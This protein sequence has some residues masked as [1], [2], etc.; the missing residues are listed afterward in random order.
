LA[1]AEVWSF[2]PLR[3]VE[4]TAPGAMGHPLRGFAGK[5]YVGDPTMG[6]ETLTFSVYLGATV[7]AL[8][9][10]ALGRGRSLAWFLGG[11]TIVALIIAMGR[12][13][14]VHR[15]T[16]WLAPPL[17]FMRYPEK[18]LVIVAAAVPLL[19]GLGV[20]RLLADARRLWRRWFVF[21]GALLAMAI[22]VVIFP[23]P[24][25]PLVRPASLY[26]TAAV[27]LLILLV[28]ARKLLRRQLG[29]AV[30]V[31]LVTLD[32]AFPV[33]DL[34]D[35]VDADLA[36]RVPPAATH[37]LAQRASPVAPPRIYRYPTV[38]TPVADLTPARDAAQ[39]ESRNLLT[40]VP[41]AANVHGLA[42]LPGY[43][44]AIPSTWERLF[45]A[46]M[47][48]DPVGL[49]RL[50]ST[51]FV[52][53]ATVGP[54]SVRRLRGLSATGLDPLPGA[55]LFAVEQTLP[56][57]FAVGRTE[58]HEAHI[59][60]P[61]AANPARK[62]ARFARLF[63]PEVLAGQVALVAPGDGEARLPGPAG[64]AG[65]CTLGHYRADHV[66]A[67]CRLQEPAMVVF[68][69]QHDSRGWSA[70]INGV[71]A[72]L[73]LVNHVMRGVRAPAGDHQIELAYEPPGRTAS[74]LVS[75]FALLALL[76]MVAV[77]VRPAAAAATSGSNP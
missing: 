27:T 12:Y 25:R 38:A 29:L 36:T 37:V 17:M 59:D 51:E 9:L 70:T 73:F 26:A 16:R 13:L 18:Y 23:Q 60:E 11:V 6:G 43:D 21:A 61:S 45:E 42:S 35:F 57:V 19:A 76:A 50:T 40:L 49:F 41:N 65:I 20:D 69:E 4:M 8:A 39:D 67:R 31:A 32:L 62:Y 44:A 1:V 47:T 33:F 48:L 15:F 2:A 10:L 53:G 56:R 58:V 3:L 28:T 24:L 75:I 14:P 74:A 71:A 68:V 30:L 72:P 66:S 22:L 34:I 5:P 7:L 64:R 77:R 52:I 46:G 55:R 63:S 54:H